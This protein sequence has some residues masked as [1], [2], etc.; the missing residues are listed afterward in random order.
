MSKLLLALV[1]V[2]LL[3]SL[4]WHWSFTGQHFQELDSEWTYRALTEF[5]EAAYEYQ[6]W[7]YSHLKQK[8][9]KE[10]AEELLLKSYIQ[11]ALPDSLSSSHERINFISEMHPHQIYRYFLIDLA[12][13]LPSLMQ[14]PLALTLTTTYSAG[15]ALVYQPIVAAT[16]NWFSFRKW[17][18]R[19]NHL[20][21]HMSVLLFFLALSKAYSKGV[22]LFCCL[23]LLGSVSLYSYSYHMGSTIWNIMIPL[24]WFSIL[25]LKPEHAQL[26]NWLAALAMLF[27]YTF[28]IY[29]FCFILIKLLE[30]PKM[31]TLIKAHLPA[32]LV[33][34]LVM[35][36]FLQPGQGNRA[37]LHIA[38]AFGAYFYYSI[39]NQFSFNIG[40]GLLKWLQAGSFGL[41]FL[42]GIFL[43]IKSYFQKE[44]IGLVEKLS[45]LV[46]V[47]FSMLAAFSI[48]GF[49]PTRHLLFLTAPAFLLVGAALHNLELNFQRLSVYLSVILLPLII[50]GQVERRSK[51]VDGY[52]SIMNTDHPSLLLYD[53]FYLADTKV[54]LDSRY[55]A[56]P[57]Q[58]LP[59]TLLLVT[60]TGSARSYCLEELRSLYQPLE[61]HVVIQPSYFTAYN[62][63]PHSFRFSRPNRAYTAI[64]AKCVDAQ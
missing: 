49:A 4:I 42:L 50:Y 45:L 2:C 40:S 30:K 55:G 14:S 9:G 59:D 28:F 25:I 18:G 64:L 36:L 11:P 51:V 44:P 5:P 22:A 13:S 63:R 61:E 35:L 6:A 7:S 57:L 16:S 24:I 62:H 15:M 56:I 43:M 37:N 41:L 20:L 3:T 46:L 38:S 39:L 60:Q 27:S 29:Y 31:K 17:A 34:G 12:A 23:A 58:Q 52:L 33:G 8:V 47:L 1:I 26:H 53:Q 10:W 21:F 19:L 54:E 48:M 32:L